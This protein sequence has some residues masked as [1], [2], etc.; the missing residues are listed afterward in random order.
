[1]VGELRV[2]VGYL[3]E[4]L[5]D[6]STTLRWLAG[7][8]RAQIAL[9]VVLI[10]GV[11]LVPPV[12]DAVADGIF[13]PKK[14][15]RFLRTRVR[16]NPSAA[17]LDATLTFLYWL[18]SSAVV[19]SLL[20][21]ELPGVLRAGGEEEEG[22][23]P[24]DQLASAPTMLHLPQ[25]VAVEDAASAA[26]MAVE[27]VPS[28][29]KDPEGAPAERYSIVGE[30]GRGGMGVVHRAVDEVLGREVALKAL[31]EGA[32]H[33][34]A[35]V[36]RFRQE[37]RALAQLNHDNIVRVYDL[38][39]RGSERFIAMEL[40]DGQDL[41]EVIGAGGG[42]PVDRVLSL[43]L[44]MAEAL[45]YAHERGVVHRDFKP[46]NVLVDSAGRP[47][48]TDF[49]LA[50]IA[51]GPQLTSHGAILGSP[52]YMSPEQASGKA[53]DA[54]VDTYSLGAT[55]Y[56]LRAGRP[57]FT[58]ET[59]DVLESH[60]HAEPPR[61]EDAPEELAALVAEMLSKSPTD[62]PAMAEVVER[63]AGIRL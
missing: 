4:V 33:N 10:A 48:I 32:G 13:E 40:V 16:R 24:S 55:I 62:R 6:R 1:M 63:L 45:A 39:E 11:F 54:A 51:E 20:A 15:R 60:L 46:G 29:A 57:P 2:A 3:P 47:K 61:L 36:S 44:S 18:G 23:V 17:T 25:T 14:V 58:G 34:E 59:L 42:L 12:F 35:L 52:H 31:P 19:V 28:P 30:I 43:A 21:L 9:G 26:T 50:K 7:A 8:R 38:V 41:S 27:A 37:A 22:D 49:G 53:V 5:S 56:E